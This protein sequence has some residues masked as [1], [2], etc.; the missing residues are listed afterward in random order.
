MNLD[1]P[2]AALF[3]LIAVALVMVGALLTVGIV[4]VEQR[5]AVLAGIVATLFTIAWRGRHK[6]D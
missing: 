3:A 5:A 4:S 6:E 2:S 1:P